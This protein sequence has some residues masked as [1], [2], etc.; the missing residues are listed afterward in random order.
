[1]KTRGEFFMIKEMYQ[2]GMSITDIA[3]ELK[4]DRKTVKK[5]I[6]SETVPTSRKRNRSSKLDEFKD[7]INRRMLE[8]R[9]FKCRETA[10]RDQV[11][12]ISRW[13][14]DIKGLYAALSGTS[15]KEIYCP[16]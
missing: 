2:R 13:Q 3:K 5:Y 16:L 12:W 10:S 11:A 14:N 4:M 1:M 15:K 9:V 8:N 7:Y 6:M